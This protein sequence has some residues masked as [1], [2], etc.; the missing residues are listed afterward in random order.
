VPA[1]AWVLG[2][3]GLAAMGV[4][5]YF[6]ATGLS[7]S[8]TLHTTCSPGCTDAQVQP[9]RTKLIVAD[10]GLGVGVLSFAAAIWIGVRGL[11]RS[12]RAQRA[13]PWEVA[14]VPSTSGARASF[15]LRF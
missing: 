11:T 10:V 9:V 15:V 13:A 3:V 2:G 6:G 7:D 14:V 5:A 12:R 4:F 1:G 8:N